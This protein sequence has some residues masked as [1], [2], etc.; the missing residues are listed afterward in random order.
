MIPGLD[1]Q[2]TG[3]AP[4]SMNCVPRRLPRATAVEA[5]DLAALG[6][7]MRACTEAQRR[8]HPSLV[9]ETRSA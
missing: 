1:R 2:G 8:L 4:R 7:A 3:R 9:G 5:E 6:A